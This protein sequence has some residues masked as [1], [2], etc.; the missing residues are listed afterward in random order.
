MPPSTLRPELGDAISGLRGR[1]DGYLR[2]LEQGGRESQSTS[3][4]P[5]SKLTGPVHFAPGAA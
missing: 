2:D 5:L 4:V 1:E 3:H